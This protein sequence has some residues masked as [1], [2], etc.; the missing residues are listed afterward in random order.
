MNDAVERLEDRMLSVVVHER[1]WLLWRRRAWYRRHVGWLPS[2]YEED[3]HE[4]RQL[5]RLARE[6]RGLAA[7][8]IRIAEMSDPITL[9]KGDHFRYAS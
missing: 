9:A 7:P 6:A 1:I 5:V 3:R 4:L 8:A 2:Q